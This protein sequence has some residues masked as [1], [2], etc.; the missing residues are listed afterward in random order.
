MRR[1]ALMTVLLGALA[2]SALAEERFPPPDF[3]SHALPLTTTPAPRSSAMQWVDV[4]A[5]AAALAAAS[6]LA[7]RARSRKGLALLMLASLAYFG[8]VRKGC[9][10]SIGAIQNVAMALFDPTYAL[11]LTVAVFF[12]LPL[13]FTLFFGRTFCAAVCP[14]GAIQD[15]ALLRPVSVPAWLEHALGLMPY[16]YLGAAVLMATTG[17]LFIICHY[18]PFVGFFRLGMPLAMLI[19]GGA[20]LLAGVF[21]GRPYC[22]FACPYGAMLRWLSPL[23]KWHVTITPDEC[24]RCRLCEDACPFGA[25]EKPT[26][27]GVFARREGKGLLA[28]MLLLLPALIVVG[29]WAGRKV[30]PAMAHANPTV[31]LARL[32]SLDNAGKLPAPSDLVAAFRRGSLSD[33]ALMDQAATLRRQFRTGGALLGGFIGL[34]IGGKLVALCVRRRR[35][36]YQ[37]RKATC[38]SCGRC[39]KYCPVELKRQPR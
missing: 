28:V 38:V 29:A 24:V 4:A 19:L 10:C 13:A 22:R 7:I 17:S 16:V 26:P 14:L 9:V 12:L 2:V 36:D 32:V 21:V 15:V 23:A 37:P 33:A 31:R 18:D 35:T 8:F 25:I 39:L 30:S 27:P 3:T 6:Y 11:P 5:L 34:V 1:V 20:I